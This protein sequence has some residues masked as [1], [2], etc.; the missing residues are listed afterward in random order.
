MIDIIYQAGQDVFKALSCALNVA[1]ELTHKVF[2][3]TSSE[4]VALGKEQSEQAKDGPGNE[5]CQPDDNGH[6]EVECGIVEAE[7]GKALQF[8]NEVDDDTSTVRMMASMLEVDVDYTSL[9]QDHWAGFDG[10]PTSSAPGLEDEHS[11][12]GHWEEID[13]DPS[14]LIPEVHMELCLAS[15]RQDFYSAR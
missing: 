2:S 4:T 3:G 5:Y 14:T 11:C 13:G 7:M 1:D 9:T 15:V 10:D 8:K 6:V 12:C